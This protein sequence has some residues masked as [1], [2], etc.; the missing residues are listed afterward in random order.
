MASAN[1]SRVLSVALQELKTERDR[2]GAAIEELEGLLQAAANG[3]RRGGAR[4]LA[5]PGRRPGR[6]PGR[7][8][9]PAAVKARSIRGWTSAKRQAA[10]LRMKRYW[11]ERRAKT[12]QA[13]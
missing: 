1:T 3:G 10:A 12:Q 7:V 4:V 9:R 5:R 13:Q 11:A 8:Q 2:I 6:K